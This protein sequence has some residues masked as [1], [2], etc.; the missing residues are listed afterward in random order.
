MISHSSNSSS[1]L[2][3]GF[4]TFDFLINRSQFF[5]SA[6]AGSA[7]TEFSGESLF[8]HITVSGVKLVVC[9]LIKWIDRNFTDQVKSP[10][11]FYIISDV[12]AI[13]LCSDDLARYA[14]RKKGFSDISTDKAAFSIPANAEIKNT[15][16]DNLRLMPRCFRAHTMQQGIAGCIFSGQRIGF[17]LDIGR[18]LHNAL[19]E[20]I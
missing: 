11:H 17:W 16:L 7:D 13:A 6:S 19:E 3:A 10:V 18:I 12:Q 2:H 14:L 9:N 8:S 5:S 15:R 20:K 4:R 1:F